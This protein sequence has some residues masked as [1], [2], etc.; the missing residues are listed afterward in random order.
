M[1]DKALDYDNV[2]SERMPEENRFLKVVLDF[3][4]D[5]PTEMAVLP[6][7]DILFLNVRVS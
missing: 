2:K 4:L 5:E 3:N 6:N 1:G 7:G